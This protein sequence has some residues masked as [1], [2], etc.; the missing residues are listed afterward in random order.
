MEHYLIKAIYKL[1]PNAEFSITDNDYSTIKWDVLEG[2]APTQKEI[3]A[4]IKQVK[5]DEAN[6]IKT[7]ATAKAALLDRLGIT[8]DE[9]KLLLS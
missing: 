6:A 2:E 8:E 3:D 7:K 4:A 5:I 1:K 9:A